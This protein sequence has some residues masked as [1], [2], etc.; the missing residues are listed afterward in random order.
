MSSGRSPIAASNRAKVVDSGAMTGVP[1]FRSTIEGGSRGAVLAAGG[2]ATTG[3]I[4]AG[5]TGGGPG[6]RNRGSGGGAGS[7]AEPRGARLAGAAVC[8]GAAGLRAAAPRR[9]G[10]AQRLIAVLAFG[11]ASSLHLGSSHDSYR[12]VLTY[13]SAVS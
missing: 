2:V 8:G 12:G 11:D 7:W 4:G 13:D 5:T 9:R 1:F 3:V 10:R 6:R